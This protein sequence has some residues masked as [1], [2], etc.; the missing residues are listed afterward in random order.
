M[1]PKAL[2]AALAK[3]GINA[4]IEKVT[5]PERKAAN[6]NY[7]HE[8]RLAFDHVYGFLSGTTIYIYK[9]DNLKER[10]QAAYESIKHLTAQG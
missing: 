4:V 9:N 8:Y 2:I 6:P 5:D 1:T 3:H 7:S 10:L